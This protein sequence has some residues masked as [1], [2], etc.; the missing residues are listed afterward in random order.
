ML[1]SSFPLAGYSTTQEHMYVNAV[2]SI[3]P[4]FFFPP[5]SRSILDVCPSILA[6]QIASSVLFFQIP[7]TYVNIQYLFSSF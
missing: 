7:H 6:L 2:L 3:H 4:T 5:P 1:H